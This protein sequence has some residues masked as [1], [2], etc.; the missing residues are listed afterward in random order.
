MFVTHLFSWEC[1]S[2]WFCHLQSADYEFW[3]SFGIDL[4][5]AKTSQFS[6]QTLASLWWAILAIWKFCWYCYESLQN[7]CCLPIAEGLTEFDLLRLSRGISHCRFVVDWYTGSFSAFSKM[8]W[9]SSMWLPR[10]LLS[11]CGGHLLGQSFASSGCGRSQ[12]Q[13]EDH[14]GSRPHSF[15][16]LCQMRSETY[17]EHFRNSP[18]VAGSGGSRQ[19]VITPLICRFVSHWTLETTVC[20]SSLN[21]LRNLSYVVFLWSRNIRVLCQLAPGMFL[22]FFFVWCWQFLLVSNKCHFL[23]KTACWWLILDCF[24]EEQSNCC[25]TSFLI[26]EVTI[27]LK[28]ST[29]QW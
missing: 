16:G 7:C 22:T 23:R 10:E 25:F 27:L 19:D 21:F 17:P 14:S 29:T 12:H 26:I 4:Q 1:G 11:Q 3:G 2:S 8:Y 9:G 15:P 28:F 20:D 13:D 5:T 6:R 18:E 24:T